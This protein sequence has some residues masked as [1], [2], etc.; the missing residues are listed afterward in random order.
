MTNRFR[1]LQFK[2]GQAQLEYILIVA[3]TLFVTMIAVNGVNLAR[4]DTGG[5][6]GSDADVDTSDVNIPTTNVVTIPGLKDALFVYADRLYRWVSEKEPRETF[7]SHYL[8]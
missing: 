7:L 5:S 4:V 8:F 6:Y 3:L 1:Q 2:R